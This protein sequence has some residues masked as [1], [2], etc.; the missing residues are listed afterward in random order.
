[1]FFCLL[2]F[3]SL[4]VSGQQFRSESKATLSD[5]EQEI[6]KKRAVEKTK[7]LGL[8][9]A[10]ICN[11]QIDDEKLKLNTIDAA[12]NLFMS[13]DRVVQVSGSGKEIKS[14]EIRKY[15]TRLNAL[16][17]RQIN[18]EWFDIAYIRDL[19][20]APDGTYYGTISIIQKFEG[21]NQEGKLA[22]HDQTE[23]HIDIIVKKMIKRIGDKAIEQWEVLLGDIKIA[24]TKV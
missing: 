5:E 23:K 4:A 20:Q 21:Y 24:E 7:S 10:T 13:E 1:M 19:K 16:P 6:F 14:Y 15:L 2:L 3:G 22:Y 18:M 9:I 12:V 11:K 8:Y 17:Y